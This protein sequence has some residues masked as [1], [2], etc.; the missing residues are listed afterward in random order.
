MPKHRRLRLKLSPLFV[1]F[2]AERVSKLPSGQR[3][4]AV[5]NSDEADWYLHPTKGWRKRSKPKVEDTDEVY[6]DESEYEAEDD[7]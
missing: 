4:V 2:G 7:T 6:E 3:A 5:I 1:R